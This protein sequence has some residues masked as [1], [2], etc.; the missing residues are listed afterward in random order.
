[1]LRQLLSRLCDLLAIL[2]KH[3]LGADQMG[4]QA[5]AC[6]KLEI[7]EE[8]AAAAYAAALSQ[9]HQVMSASFHKQCCRLTQYTAD[10]HMHTCSLW[11]HW[12]CSSLKG[13]E[14]APTH[15]TIDPH[16]VPSSLLDGAALLT[17][18]DLQY[19]ALA[20][21]ASHRFSPVEP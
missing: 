11:L 1:M 15:G 5:S 19:K 10:L 6:Y 4:R 2:A 9:Q 3:H 8:D 13:I 14:S 16:C 7:N 12:F 21:R 18:P 17:Q 20:Q